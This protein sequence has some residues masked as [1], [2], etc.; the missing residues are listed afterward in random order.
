QFLSI[1]SHELK[2]P[3]SALLLEAELL[4]RN[5]A[6]PELEP[7]WVRERTGKIIRNIKRLEKLVD[8][9]LDVSRLHGGETELEAERADLRLL[10]RD[11]VERVSDGLNRSGSELRLSVDGPT[12]SHCD[13]KRIDQVLTNLLTNAMKYGQGRPIDVRVERHAC[14]A[15]MIV[16]DHG[17]G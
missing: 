3:L 15:R 5:A 10:A 12:F 14:T 11:V 7:H 9:L 16:R 4:E 8:E 2:T 6:G 1:A 17:I 13:A